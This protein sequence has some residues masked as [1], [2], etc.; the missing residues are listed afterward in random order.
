MSIEG[1]SLEQAVDDLGHQ[2]GPRPMTAKEI[3]AHP[4]FPYVTWLLTPTRRERVK[5]GSGRGG[6]FRICYEI[7]GKGP[8]KLVVCIC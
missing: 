7:H 4:E 2:E 5:V 8:I 3:L 6:P 1:E